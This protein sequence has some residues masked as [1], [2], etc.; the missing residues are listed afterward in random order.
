MVHKGLIIFGGVVLLGLFFLVWGVSTYNE[1]LSLRESAHQNWNQ[2]N[3][4]YKKRSD[5]IP[6][7]IIT[8][9]TFEEL[10]Q[11]VADDLTTRWES[12]VQFNITT[13]VMNDSV[14]FS[15]YQEVQNALSES[16]SRLLVTV[17]DYPAIKDSENFI[18]YQALLLGAENRV[19]VE[20]N[21]FNRIIQTYN[22]EIGR[23]PGFIIAA[24]FDF[25]EKYYFTSNLPRWQFQ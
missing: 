2:M 25:N 11:N 16:I 21:N 17:E 24:M 18:H 3:I 1:F 10:D 19:V 6:G 7:L 20:R 8:L 12:V 4:E 15:E 14:L 23:F 22:T 13:G 9:N 5:I